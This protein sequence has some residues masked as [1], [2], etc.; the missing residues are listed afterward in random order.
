MKASV[1][2]SGDQAGDESDTPLG[3]C[4]TTWPSTRTWSPWAYASRRPSGDHA[5]SESSSPAISNRRSLP[6]ARML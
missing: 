2:P 1:P 3:G 5:G 4:V 6:S